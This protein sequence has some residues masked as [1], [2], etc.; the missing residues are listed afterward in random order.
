M[1]TVYNMNSKY[2]SFINNACHKI[3]A[4]T[5]KTPSFNNL[6][7]SQRA[8]WNDKVI[9]K[10]VELQNT[11]L[12]DCL[13]MVNGWLISW[14]YLLHHYIDVAYIQKCFNQFWICHGMHKLL[15]YTENKREHFSHSNLFHTQLTYC[16]KRLILLL[17]HETNMYEQIFNWFQ[18]TG[19]L[20]KGR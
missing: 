5:S 10:L 4:S 7:Q 19:G 14:V 12:V 15:S 2:A 18:D 20:F 8:I 3:W 13:L 16:S 1:W 6:G 9:I 11:V 17:L